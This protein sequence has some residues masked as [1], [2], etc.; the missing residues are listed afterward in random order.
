VRN[1]EFPNWRPQ[2]RY[3]LA[4]SLVPRR[5]ATRQSGLSIRQTLS[6]QFAIRAIIDARSAA[7]SNGEVETSMADVDENV[8]MFD[9]V[10]PLC[11]I[12]KASSLARAQN[13]HATFNQPPRLETRDVEVF[14][15]GDVAFTHFL[16]H[17]SGTQKTGQKVEMWF[18]TTLGFE[19]KQ[20]RWWI[21]HEHGSVPF[22]PES[23]QVSLGLYAAGRSLMPRSISDGRFRMRQRPEILSTKTRGA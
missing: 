19:R 11:H 1:N 3:V 7:V 10:D 9:L 5:R 6:R 21:V 18:R 23:G 2:G 12:G 20:G 13:W 4:R 15:S 16:S 22:N 14:L 8:V 17:V